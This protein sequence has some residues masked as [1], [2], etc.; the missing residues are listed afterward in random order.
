MNPPMQPSVR[1]AVILAGGEG[2]RLRELTRQIVGHPTPKQFCPVV[3]DVC[4]LEQ[5]RRRVSLS[6]APQ[7]IL[8]VVNRPHERFYQASMAH[9]PKAQ[10]VVQPEG[11]GTAAA[12]VYALM[13]AARIAPTASIAIFPADHYVDNDAAFMRHVDAA[14][15]GVEQRPEITVLLGISP[16]R[17]EPGYGWIEPARPLR[18][19]SARFFTVRRFWE[20]PPQAIA[21]E[22]M[23]SGCLW[24]SFVM[25]G[26]VSTLLGLVMM[27][28]PQ[29]YSS[30]NA[31]R[32]VLGTEMEPSKLKAIYARL[33]PVDFSSDILAGVPVN[34]TVLPVKGVQW[35][36]L[37]EPAR[38]MDTLQR[39]GARPR[40]AAA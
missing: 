38:V 13:R 37:G 30:F 9:H 18:L 34:L 8:T 4:L 11:R 10:L 17:P 2:S 24:N 31:L 35:S 14:F 7:H 33:A 36:D 12:I 28:Q 23:G 19:G 29:L 16:D 3:G 15:E 5:T 21:R 1:A 40:W 6:V 32:P 22:L 25:V 26:R 39:L 27:T 20:K